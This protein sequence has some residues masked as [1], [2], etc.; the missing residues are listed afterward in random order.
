MK[1]GRRRRGGGRRKRRG[2]RRKRR[3]G[4]R[5]RKRRRDK[6]PYRKWNSIPRSQ[7]SSGHRARVSTFTVRMNWQAVDIRH[8]IRKL[9]GLGISNH[10]LFTASKRKRNLAMSRIID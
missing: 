10:H 6:H 8:K 4:R 5:R 1:K 7:P 9:E 2:G 3:G